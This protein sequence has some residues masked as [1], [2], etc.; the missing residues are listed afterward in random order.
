MPAKT[1]LDNWVREKIGIAQDVG[2]DVARTA[3]RGRQLAQLNT[4]LERA[5]RKS[6][7]YRETLAN[8][9]LSPLSSLEEISR[10]PFTTPDTLSENPFAF[11]AVPQGEIERVVTLRTSGTT[12]ESK[13]LFFTAVDL[14]HTMDFFNH[15]MSTMVD[16]G[17]KVAVFLP[18][19]KP[20]TVGDLLKR[21]LARMEIETLVYGIVDDAEKAV[22]AAVDFGA[23]CVVGIPTQI[24]SLACAANSRDLQKTLKTALLTTDYVPSSLVARVENS[25]RCEVY[26]HY[27]MTE[28]GLGGGVECQAHG[29]YHL[30]EAEFYYEIVD[31]VVGAA[32]GEGEVGEVVVTS[33]CQ[34]GTPLIRYRT[35][36]RARFLPGECEC[37]TFLRRMEKV[38]GRFSNII[39]LAPDLVLD[40]SLLD[41]ALFAIEGLIDYK[42]TATKGGE[43]PNLQLAVYCAGNPEEVETNCRESLTGLLGE[44][45]CGERSLSIKFGDEGRWMLNGASKRKILL[46]PN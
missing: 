27:G 11:L 31:P 7:Y 32:I 36:D 34:Q 25:L 38:S 16:P 6:P 3:L 41:E 9:V 2:N 46:Q 10:I 44:A 33:L 18:G 15:G 30:R 4:S 26:N 22:M 19:G 17:Q 1:P 29:G 39:R 28:T 20:D 21:A 23:H 24:L 8:H 14:E 37:G 43:G 40:I 12:G 13:R 35:G 5:A 42:F 45:R